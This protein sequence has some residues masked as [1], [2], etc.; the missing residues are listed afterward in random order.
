MVFDFFTNLGLYLLSKESLYNDVYGFGEWDN[1]WN[2]PYN[3]D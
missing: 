2:N 3:Q 1:I